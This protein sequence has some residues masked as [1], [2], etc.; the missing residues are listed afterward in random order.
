M[1]V[2]RLEYFEGGS[3]N[4]YMIETYFSSEERDAAVARYL[5][6]GGDDILKITSKR[7]FDRIRFWFGKI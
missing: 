1:T 5:R 3:P 6:L 7:A 4:A 2:W